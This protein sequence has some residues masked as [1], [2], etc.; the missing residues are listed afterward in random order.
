MDVIANE[1]F[2]GVEVHLFTVILGASVMIVLLRLT[3][4]FNPFAQASRASSA[5][6]GDMP[7]A[8]FLQDKSRREVELGEKIA[9]SHDTR[10]FRFLLPAGSMRLGLPVGKHLKVFAPNTS[11]V[12]DGEWN[13][14]PDADH[15]KSEIERKYTPT[16]STDSEGFF[17]LVIKVYKGGELERFPDGGKMSQYLDS[18]AVG[19]KLQVSGPYGL[20]EYRGGGVFKTMKHEHEYHR[21]G[22]IAGG[23]GITPMLQIIAAVLQT[24]NDLTEL[25]LL[26]ANKTESDIL[27]REMLEALAKSH[28]DRFELHYTLDNPPDEWSY[29]KGFVNAEMIAKHL[30]PADEKTL[31][32]M[33]GPP[34][35]IKFA[36]R[37]ALEKLGYASVNVKE[38]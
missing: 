9:L 17:D 15:E 30:P 23:T 38:C 21:I 14:R 1:D 3:C 2:V 13:G 37:P 16:S 5:K 35:M 27:V 10:L 18:L 19:D 29:S 11:G 28:P 12:V 32:L 31:I 36:C 26:Y 34:P 6:V 4:K 24:P 33:C 8:S 7:Q 20:H 25:S 22:M